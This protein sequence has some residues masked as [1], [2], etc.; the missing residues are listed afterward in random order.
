MSTQPNGD[1][2]VSCPRPNDA[3]RLRLFCFPY[4]GGGASAYLS[5]ARELPPSVELCAIKL[6][7]REA[8][9]GEPP[10]ERLTPLVQ[11]AATALSPWLTRPFALFGHSLGA[12]VSFELTRELRRRGAR[13]P[14]HL[15]VSA[16]GAPHLPS[17]DPLH[18]LPDPALVERIRSMGGTPEE[19]LREPDLMGLFLP[20]VRAD[21]AVNELEPFIAEA[22]LACPITAFGGLDDARARRNEI[23]AW[24]EHTRAAFRVE[25]FPGGHFFLRS[26][27]DLFLRSLSTALDGIARALP[28]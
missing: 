28:A 16:R 26:A 13:S 27:Q 25:M 11:A 21:A 14:Q 6:P 18:A 2:W 7:G 22:P 3:A 10:F 8:R 17:A 12:L 23:E 5:W 4:A 1:A 9:L 15:F 20:I 19:V 24:R